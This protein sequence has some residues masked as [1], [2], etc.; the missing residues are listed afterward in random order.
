MAFLMCAR[1]AV[2]HKVAGWVRLRKR[3]MRGGSLIS[4]I[5]CTELENVTDTGLSALFSGFS[6][7]MKALTLSGEW[8]VIVVGVGL[9]FFTLISFCSNMQI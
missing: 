9:F 5:E 8:L 4:N 2:L 6:E 7:N 3:K 1:V